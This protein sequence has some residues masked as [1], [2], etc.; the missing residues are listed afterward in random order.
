MK[1]LR[2]KLG[3]TQETLGERI[4][5]TQVYIWKIEH[6]DIEGLTIGKLK[7][8]AHALQITPVKLLE[9]LLKE[10]RNRENGCI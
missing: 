6:G 5:V 10:E 7:K 4:G 8:L 9:I 3:Y 2:K 1:E